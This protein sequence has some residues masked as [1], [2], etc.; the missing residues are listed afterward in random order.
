M[1]RKLLILSLLAIALTACTEETILPSAQQQV[2]NRSV[3]EKVRVVPLRIYMGKKT[4]SRTAG[5]APTFETSFGEKTHIGDGGGMGT[6]VARNLTFY[7]YARTAKSTNDFLYD[8]TKSSVLNTAAIGGLK[9]KIFFTQYDQT[10]FYTAEV[11]FEKEQ[12][13]EYKILVTAS[14]AE[15]E[16]GYVGTTLKTT[17]LQKAKALTYLT[18]NAPIKNGDKLS[19]LKAKVVNDESV[20]VPQIRT[21][22]STKDID[23]ESTP[24]PFYGL[25]EGFYGF[26]ESK[27]ATS[28]DKNIIT[29]EDPSALKAYLVRNVARVEF[30]FTNI[31][32]DTTYGTYSFPWIGIYATQ[33]GTAS[34]AYEYSCFRTSASPITETNGTLVAYYDEKGKGHNTMEDGFGTTVFSSSN[35]GT[36]SFV[37]YMLPTTTEFKFRVQWNR[38][39]KLLYAD[40]KYCHNISLPLIDAGGVGGYDDS[41]TAIL[42]PIPFEGS[43]LK[44]ECNRNYI[45]T[46]DCGARLKTTD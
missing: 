1:K 43:K 46:V 36:Y 13:K 14:G 4:S 22:G 28:G 44:I 18:N 25:Q 23:Y 2:T 10:T 6:S 32:Y 38:K 7:V 17:H 42:A 20:Y 33:V 21:E 16:N 24:V 3:N 19:D 27:S 9:A 15:E 41:G 30:K 29:Y 5:V 31:Y 45:I 26:C 8:E 39:G 34:D 40:N 11:S 35:P 12:G 37:T